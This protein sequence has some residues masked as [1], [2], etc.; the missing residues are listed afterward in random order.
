MLVIRNYT[1]VPIFRIGGRVPPLMCLQGGLKDKTN[2]RT[3]I[4][5]Y[6][7]AYTHTHIYMYMDIG[8]EDICQKLRIAAII[9]VMSVRPHELQP[10]SSDRVIEIS[11]FQFSL[12]LSKHGDFC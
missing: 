3:H 10:R 1:K 2:T 8:F 5:V 11:Y 7:Y 6:T 12:K 4:Y 9:F